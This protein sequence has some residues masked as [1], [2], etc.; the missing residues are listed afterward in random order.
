MKFEDDFKQA[1]KALPEAEKDKLLMRLLKHDIT[2]ANRLYFELLDGR[3]VDT[4][5][6]DVEAALT[7]KAQH[8]INT[9][10]SPGY[11]MM[12]MR[13]MSGDISEH[14]K[15][16]KDKYGE[17]YLSLRMMVMT[18]EGCAPKMSNESFGRMAKLCVYVVAK[19]FNIMVLMHKLHPDLQYEL[20][21]D[22]QRLGQ[23]IAHD[24]RMMRTAI[25]H[26]LDVNFLLSAEIP[27]N[28]AE[29]QKD[30]RQRGYLK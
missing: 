11:L 16:A 14:V 21:N 7:T 25:Y 22:L 20:K 13:F 4:R 29:L 28:I 8:A 26:G 19:A 17:V 2:L 1:I 3:T 10:H 18:L 9:Y 5:R 30:L 27:N 23:L 6:D 15:I 12:D 24:D